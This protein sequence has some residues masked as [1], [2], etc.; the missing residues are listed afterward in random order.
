MVTDSYNLYNADFT[1]Y[2]N[3]NRPKRKKAL[4]L[5]NKSKVKKADM[6]SIRENIKIIREV[7]KAEG[8]G[9]VDAIYKANNIPLIRRS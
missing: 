1:A 5:W 2:Y 3:A 6:E 9:W 8:T 4:K 7:E